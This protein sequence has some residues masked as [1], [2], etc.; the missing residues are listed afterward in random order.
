MVR[1]ADG[2]IYINTLIDTE[3]IVL[4]VKQIRNALKN[5]TED[6]AKIGAITQSS[7]RTVIST[8]NQTGDAISQQE[9][10]VDS[11]KQKFEE[12][13][14]TKVPTQEYSTISKEIEK[15]EASLD[16]AIEKE[17]KFTETGGDT[18][19]RTFKGMEYDIEKISAALE[20]A[21]K[22]KEQLE[23]TGNAFQPE[24]TSKVEKQ[25]ADASQ[26]LSEMQQKEASALA[27]KEAKEEAARRKNE[28]RVN[29]EM[30]NI[31]KLLAKEVQ[32]AMEADRLKA[33]GE[34][35]EVSDQHII[36]LNN[37]LDRLKARQAD[38][39][40]AG[41]GFGYAEFDQNTA[42]IAEIQQELR[43]YQASL[44]NSENETVRFSDRIKKAFS[45]ISSVIKK[46]GIAM[47]GFHKN[48]KKTNRSLSSNLKMLLKYG[49][50]IRSVF[51]LFNRFRRALV[52]GFKNLAQYDSQTNKSISVL[53]SSLTQ[54]KNSFATAFNPLLTM[55]TPA[56][57]SFI[58]AMSRAITYVGMLIA[59]L[60]GAS[61]FTK[62]T[63]VQEDYAASLGE[64]ADNAK[65]AEKYLSGLDE[66]KTYSDNN[67]SASGGYKAPT[68]A[69]MFE[70]TQIDGKIKQFADKVKQTFTEMFAP[71]KKAWNE[72]GGSI[73][74]TLGK[75]KN[76]IVDFGKQIGASTVD[77][78]KNLNWDPL[79]ASVDNLL[80]GL[81][82]LVDV[83]L[84]GLAWAWENVLLPLG[85][86][87]IEEAL[88]AL[89]NALGEAFAFV[90]Q[91]LEDL[92][93]LFDWL[94]NTVLKE[95]SS[96]VGE[97]IIDVVNGFGSLLAFF[98]DVFAGDWESAFQ[99]L[100]KAGSYFKDAF[101]DTCEGIVQIISNTM[102]GA[103]STTTE[104][105]GLMNK[106]S[107]KNLSELK[108]NVNENFIGI[109]NTAK[110]KSESTKKSVS[111]NIGQLKENVKNKF[112]ETENSTK[113]I[114]S[115]IKENLLNTF[116]TVKI[117]ANNVS[118]NIGNALSNAFQRV[119]NIIGDLKNIFGD[120]KNKASETV[121]NIVSFFS[122]IRLPSIPMPH[123]SVGTETV[124]I[125]GKSFSIPSVS[126]DW[127]A[128]GGLFNQPSLIGVGEAGKE[129][130]LP[131]ENRKTMSA[132]ANSI[133]ANL[134]K[135]YLA[136]G[137]VVPPKAQYSTIN[138]ESSRRQEMD[139][140]Y[141][142]M[143]DVLSKIGQEQGRG[144]SV[145]SI[146]IPI[147]LDG[148]Q[149]F[150]AVIDEARMKQMVSGRN[151]FE[152]A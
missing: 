20:E 124:S 18:E 29:A 143:K 62:A 70:V 71:L 24:D 8:L 37:E 89:I 28:A 149:I 64:T 41:V 99:D 104:K 43:D 147:I 107:S 126:V 84:D 100:E 68:P 59:A 110:E 80:K 14:Q 112:V 77:W 9:A 48:S 108:E 152:M 121:S 135:P 118:E 150:E 22:K 52:D 134:P 31:E 69:E 50:G 83:V 1:T 38:L 127:Y 132:I 47:L 95:L 39:G 25:L 75:I 144:S 151:P 105:T 106:N 17:I 125:L 109:E 133:V 142:M 58:Q 45:G 67:D 72:Y 111:Q 5:A 122:N 123:F 55:I 11:L 10:K 66:I 103:E 145:P 101:S 137:A 114:W 78:F 148:R 119:S 91:V 102:N 6:V 120:I 98:K 4:G 128:Q 57:N 49:L 81:Q 86:W 92:Q 34:S 74:E 90:A 26:K 116:N 139:D 82:P 23:I 3:G 19:S 136:S 7:A 56:L 13:S 140:M 87:T 79:L 27:A 40:K 113:S 76:N 93:P 96:S 2:T 146:R 53:K 97:V 61:T 36:D 54:L 30:R 16:K 117:G 44:K 73:T 12:M 51:V 42:R 141:S 35:A 46:A 138:I 33:I 15:L 130:V 85:K 88:P 63:A 129:A 115:R 65:K 21:R 94:W 32:A 131:L 60:S